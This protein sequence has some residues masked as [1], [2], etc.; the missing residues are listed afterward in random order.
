MR[1]RESLRRLDL[2]AWRWQTVVRDIE[3]RVVVYVEYEMP[4]VNRDAEVW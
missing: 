1:Q 3:G 2:L 4:R